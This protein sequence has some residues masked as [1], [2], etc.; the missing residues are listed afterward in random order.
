MVGWIVGGDDG[1]GLLLVLIDR[2]VNDWTY[3]RLIIIIRYNVN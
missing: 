3:I 1:E 2:R